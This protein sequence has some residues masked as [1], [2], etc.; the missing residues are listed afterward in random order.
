M[1]DKLF[2]FLE[3]LSAVLAVVGAY[4]LYKKSQIEHPV[5]DYS[6]HSSSNQDAWRWRKPDQELALQLVDEDNCSRIVLPAKPLF[7]E[8]IFIA[9]GYVLGV[10]VLYLFII[11]VQR[12][13][14]WPSFMVCLLFFLMSYFL[15]QIGSRVSEISLSPTQLIVSLKFGFFFQRKFV[16]PRAPSLRID[17]RLESLFAMNTEQIAPD[18]K[19]LIKFA[20]FF[21]LARRF[22]VTVNQSQG[23]WLLAGLKQW[24]AQP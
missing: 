22:T 5:M 15:L 3:L 16:Y 12:G 14:T 1:L 19:L 13:D 11:L 4:F 7:F 20:G 24:C 6:Q 23:S 10:F 9:L 17:G 8:A 2:S 21:S 18:Y